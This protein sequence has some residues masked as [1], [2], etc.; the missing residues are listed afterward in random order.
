MKTEYSVA[1]ARDQ[2]A[3]LLRVIEAGDHVH[4][5][6]RG[7]KIAVLLSAREFEQLRER[8]VGFGVA[9]A[10]FRAGKQGRAAVVDDAFL[11]GLRD[12]GGGRE[13]DL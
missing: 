7:K 12:E 13:V 3:R 1:E 8:S 9:L 10:A 11:E 4:I 5:T 6:R 2:L